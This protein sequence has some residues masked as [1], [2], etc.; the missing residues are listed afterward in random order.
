[1][2]RPLAIWKTGSPV[3]RA[4]RAEGSFADMIREMLGDAWTDEILV[5]DCEAEQTSFPEP[6]EVAGT[7]ITG[8]PA[9]AYEAEPWMLRTEARLRE[10]RDANACV[11]GICFGHQLLGRAFG[12]RV[13][14]NP[15][16]REIG[17]V[18]LEI[19]EED[20]L[21]VAREAVRV[22]MTH[23]DSVTVLPEG[24]RLLARTALEPHAAV[25]FAER[26][27][28]VQFHPEMHPGILNHYVRER[29]D[30]LVEEG[31]VPEGL[32]DAERDDWGRALLQRFARF[33]RVG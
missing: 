29:W 4:A 28:G 33:C 14:P 25:R 8:S 32:L 7:L 16:G 27:W 15:R 18:E 13:D 20:P 30:A 21:V 6:S 26:I 19:L 5:V 11:L 12:G 31:L 1:M 24:A 3:P 10:Y 22:V 9:H 2:Q 23:Q 17:M